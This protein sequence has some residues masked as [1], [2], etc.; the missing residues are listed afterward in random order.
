MEKPYKDMFEAEQAAKVA[1]KQKI[2]MAASSLRQAHKESFSALKAKIGPLEDQLV[3]IEAAY[4]ALEAWALRRSPET[5]EGVAG[6]AQ[7]SAPRL[8]SVTC[9]E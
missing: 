3:D 1:L 4:H 9:P 7:D 6:A 5:N 2:M 8:W